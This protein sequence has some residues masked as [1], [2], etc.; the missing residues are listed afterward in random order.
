RP[1]PAGSGAAPRR[2]DRR[3]R[4][5]DDLPAATGAPR[6]RRVAC[7][8]SGAR[9]APSASSTPSPGALPI[10]DHAPSSAPR[11]RLESAVAWV[12]L[13]PMTS[14]GLASI[15]PRARRAASFLSRHRWSVPLSL[16]ST[17]SLLYLHFEIS[18]G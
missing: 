7:V 17:V 8:A 6:A 18:G 10:H 5:P 1:R 13:S 12:T 16:S 3:P 15:A 14:A 9:P 2:D 11:A 4:E